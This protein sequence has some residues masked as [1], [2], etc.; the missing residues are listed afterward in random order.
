[1]LALPV[2]AQQATAPP[3]RVAAAADLQTVLPTLLQEYRRRTGVQV[4]V[5]YGSSGTLAA[6]LLNGAPQ[7]LFL[8]ADAQ[9]PAKVVAAGLTTESEPVPYARGTLVLWARQDSPLQPISLQTLSSGRVQSL[10]M[11]DPGHA[12]YGRAAQAALEHLGLLTTLQPHLVVAENIAQAGQF[13]ESGNAQAGLLSLT[14]AQSPR[15]RQLGSYVVMPRVY[16]EIL[17]CGVVLRAGQTAAAQAFL[18]WLRLPATQA[19][20]PALGLAPAR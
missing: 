20:L 10:A 13:A 4:L 9:Y 5:S 14:L 2:R 16:P 12:P 7:D 8:G 19:E 6:Q 11:A 17:Q 3:L 15:F 18:D 1:M